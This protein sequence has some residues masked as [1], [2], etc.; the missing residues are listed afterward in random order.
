MD[1]LLLSS[2]LLSL[3]QTLR[4]SFCNL[5]TSVIFWVFWTGSGST[6]LLDMCTASG[7]GP[8]GQPCFLSALL[9]CQSLLHR[10]ARS[11]WATP[12]S[13][14][15]NY[16]PETKPWWATDAYLV[17]NEAHGDTSQ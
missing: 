7:G 12:Q 14:V 16:L 13:R 5:I 11:Q 15:T 6:S 4:H 8:L 1:D 10:P 2:S 9:P 3:L 17:G